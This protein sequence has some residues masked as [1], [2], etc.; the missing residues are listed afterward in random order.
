MNDNGP[1]LRP[2]T[3]CGGN[4]PPVTCLMQPK[5]YPGTESVARVRLSRAKVAARVE[6]PYVMFNEHVVPGQFE[7]WT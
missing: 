5:E 2:R 3:P 1:R 6:P 7:V 4:E